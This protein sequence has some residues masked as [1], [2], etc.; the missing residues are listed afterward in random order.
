MRPLAIAVVGGLLCS[1]LLT[2]FVVPCAYIL[3]QRGGE[4]A[5]GFLVGRKGS[6]R[7]AGGVL[8]APEVAEGVGD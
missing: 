1:T 6:Q 7:S 3:V 2:L 8:G 4:R 5:K